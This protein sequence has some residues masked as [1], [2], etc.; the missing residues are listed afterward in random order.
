MRPWLKQYPA[1]TLTAQREICCFC[2]FGLP[3]A[4]SGGWPYTL[5][6]NVNPARAVSELAW[7]LAQLVPYG[8]TN[9]SVL[10]LRGRMSSQFLWHYRGFY[11][12]HKHDA[13]FDRFVAFRES[14]DTGQAD[15]EEAGFLIAMKEL[16]RIGQT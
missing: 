11:I 5:T 1:T 15:M 3:P 6:D 10:V 16:S 14:D 7:S 8:G 12:R 9:N 2:F 4:T 13:F